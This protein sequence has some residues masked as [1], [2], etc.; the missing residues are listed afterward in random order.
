M[1][2]NFDNFRGTL[3]HASEIYGVFQPLL[4]W[5]SR[6]TANRLNGAEIRLPAFP[7]LVGISSDQNHMMS[8]V[9]G[10]DR[11]ATINASGVIS[12]SQPG[13]LFASPPELIR[14][15]TP[16]Y[17]DGL[18]VRFLQR[19]ARPQLVDH[20]LDDS[21]F[22]SGFWESVLSQDALNV[23]LEKAI[24]FVNGPPVFEHLLKPDQTNPLLEYVQKTRLMISDREQAA[25]Y[26]FNKEIYV[27]R[28]LHEMLP[29]PGQ[30]PLE[31]GFPANVNNLLLKVIP[32]PDLRKVLEMLDPLHLS[33]GK[34]REAALSPIGIVHLFRQ[35]YFEFENFLGPPVEHIWLSPGSTTELIEVS[36]RRV[37]Q[38][39]VFE[40]F[41]E[42]IDRSESAVTTQDELSQAVK[43]EN[44]KNSKLGS[45]ISGGATILIA[46]IE[47]SG[48]MSVE[49]T[50]RQAREETHRTSRQQSAKLSSEIRSNARSTFR[51]V[52][53]VT[54]TR[55]KR[56]TIQNTT[57]EL[58]N[59]ELRR[60]M[61]QV[62]V[63][64]QDL[65]TQLCWQVYVDDPGA[66]LGVGQLVHLASR[67]DLSEFAITPTKAEPQPL[68][69]TVTIL[70]PVPNPGDR[71][72]LGPIVA[73]GSAGFAVASVPGAIVGVAVEVVLDDL[74]GGKDK[75][76]SYDIGT[77]ETI[78]QTYKVNLPAGYQVAPKAEQQK[79]EDELFKM[80]VDGDVPIRKIG[81][82]GRNL[83]HRMN[84][85]NAA[86]GVFDLVVYGGSVTPAEICQYQ[87]KIKVV[88]TATLVD[89]VAKENA[90]I[91][92]GNK[93]KAVEKERK[94]K[95]EFIKNV[96]DRVE[97]AS[98]ITSRPPEDL[99]EEER[100]VIY[101]KLIEKLMREAWSLSASRP[102]AHLRSEVIKSIFDVDK[103]LYFVA[104][105]WWQPRRHESHLQT[106][107]SLPKY[108]PSEEVLSMN[109]AS[110][111]NLETT[112]ATASYANTQA[113]KSK[114]GSLGTEDLVGWGGEGRPDNYLIAE[115]SAPAR[116]G[117]SL[118]WLLQLD[119][120]NL[121]NAF[122]NA[123]WVK[124]VLPIRPGKE[125]DALEWL[126]QSQVEG[127]EGL[128]AVYAGDDKGIFK[129]KYTAK[130]GVVK[131][132]TVG[133]VLGLIAD[134]VE[135]K[136]DA[137]TE[138]VKEQVQ[139]GPGQMA[140]L[141]YLRP[142]RVFEKGFDPLKGGFRALPEVVGDKPQFEVFDQ[143]VEILPT[144]QI[145]A[146]AVEYDPKTGFL[147]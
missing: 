145:V 54:D 107:A 88:P 141:F 139:V 46:H 81:N 10:R 55:S 143:W 70:L 124:A 75:S 2:V 26:L 13:D 78:H 115:K 69:D 19:E 138:V 116:L 68:S 104:P 85:L 66:P 1:K 39:R 74:F 128:D 126:Q 137:A 94:I 133:D 136:S 36:T 18:I 97:L 44:R 65:G 119:G 79:G 5:K 111:V 129:A 77:Q 87:A 113:A 100:T 90:A 24:D 30:D 25:A 102:L 103:L 127:T 9:I 48:S 16:E 146:V 11:A 108:G 114:L 4:G 142:D 27:A 86:E 99:R 33:K 144:D 28:Y 63:Q 120:D 67:A 64:Q 37:L 60:K 29:Q 22:W 89:A 43:D 130:F 112:A 125:Q 93:T 91:V 52:T 147:K 76:G 131:D 6:L 84:I 41:M 32:A 40:Q 23:I 38:E 109:A 140:D 51:T 61:R 96:K 72:N 34:G 83:L 17:V 35:Y 47:A 123:P 49:E 31:V 135:S 62:G 21:A 3:P 82:N 14:F 59:Y 56:Y 71:S 12:P 101:R 50:Q 45:T 20:G 105:E 110:K 121:R 80:G 132:P 98:K 42:T 15:D 134:D 58:V 7:P 8:I 122:L 106:G 117:S 118:G 57:A 53:E 92:E 73:A 95:E